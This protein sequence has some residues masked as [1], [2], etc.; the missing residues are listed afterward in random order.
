MT[1][2]LAQPERHK[3]AEGI[4]GYADTPN[5]KSAENGSQEPSKRCVVDVFSP[6]ARDQQIKGSCGEQRQ[7]PK[8]TKQSIDKGCGVH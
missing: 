3:R 2:V 1:R 4:C 8:I 5:Q 7:L 6:V